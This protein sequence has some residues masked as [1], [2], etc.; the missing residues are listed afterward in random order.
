[1]NFGRKIAELRRRSGLS[2]IEVAEYLTQQGMPLKSKA[3][4]KWELSQNVPDAKAFLLLCKLYRVD[5]IGAEFLGTPHSDLLNGLNLPGRQRVEE[6][7]GLLRGDERFSTRS[8]RK[9]KAVRSI[10]LYDI[11][12]SA[13]LGNFLDSD[14]YDLI[15]VDESVPLDATFAVKVCGDSMLPEI[16]D[17]QI[18]YV[19]PQ[20]TLQIGQVGIFWL[21]G[22]AY[23][24]EYGKNKLVSF[25]KKYAPLEI[26]KSG[27]DF[28]IFGRVVA[29]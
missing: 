18:V 1:M 10:P 20:P 22:Q 6:Y 16:D 14:S 5:D 28:R 13:G 17:G 9:E 24:K 7:I 23:C 3:V 8:Q 11:P 12:V 15:E 2:Q 26:H 21:D 25:N 27:D 4:S 19:K 29:W